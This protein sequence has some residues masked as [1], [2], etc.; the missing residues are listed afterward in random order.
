[1][2]VSIYEVKGTNKKLTSKDLKYVDKIGIELEGGWDDPPENLHTDISIKELDKH[3]ATPMFVYERQ[4]HNCHTCTPHRFAPNGSNLLLG[5]CPDNCTSADHCDASC[6]R[7]C[8][9]KLDKSDLREIGEC[10]SRPLNIE[11]LRSWIGAYTPNVVN[12]TCGLHIHVSMK[13]EKQYLKLTNREFYDHFLK[14]MEN[15]GNEV[16]L[17][18]KHEFWSR[19]KGNNKYC[20]REFTPEVQLAMTHK[21]ENDPTRRT[22]LNFCYNIEDP[23][24]ENGNLI[25]QNEANNP[26]APVVMTQQNTINTGRTPVTNTNTTPDPKIKKRKRTTVECRLFPAFNHSGYVVSAM[27]SFVKCI[28]AYL[29]S[30]DDKPSLKSFRVYRTPKGELVERD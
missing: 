23:V 20:R 30:K 27:E 2:K 19:L 9:C 4:D 13:E 5:Y 10:I 14:W 22:H 3:V 26:V 18:K 17:P 12:E 15:W 7:S 8:S 28:E 25:I 6:D 1:M 24:D 21:P 11:E 16:G 29:E